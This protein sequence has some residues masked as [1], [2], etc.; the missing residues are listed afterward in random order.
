[1]PHGPYTPLVDGVTD[2][3][4]ANVNVVYTALE[5]TY[6]TAEVDTEI[7]EAKARANHTGTQ[8]ASTISDFDTEVSNNTDVAANTTARHTH[9][10]SAVLT[11][12]T[13][14]FLLADEAKLD[15]IEALADVTDA[16]NVGSS[17]HGA[18][19]KTTPVDADTMPL[20]DSAA[21]NVLKKVTWANVKATAKTYF[22]TLYATVSHT[23][24][25]SDVTG[26][27]EQVRDTI[28][29]ALVAGSNITVTPNDGSDTITIAGTVQPP[30]KHVPVGSLLSTL[31]HGPSVSES[32]TPNVALAL[33]ADTLYLWPVDCPHA[34]TINQAQVQVSVSSSAG[35]IRVGVFTADE[36]ALSATLVVD[37]GTAST[38]TNARKDISA[39]ATVLAAGTR[40]WLGVLVNEACTILGFSANVGFELQNLDASPS[41]RFTKAVTY[42]AFAGSYSSLTR[43]NNNP[44]ATLGLK[45]SA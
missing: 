32:A 20:I 6:T 34:M 38:T 44:V 22:D 36:S 37:C 2:A 21:S 30:A 9:A 27:D 33:T 29:T 16:G 18:T 23:H 39:S 25:T 35:S 14:S 1:M 7:T 17:I 45:R 13:A 10:N 3:E 12:V 43:S 15:A 8:A 42:A 11:A 28:G 4:A 24:A 41:R 19:A 40:Y 26:F 5:D 31:V